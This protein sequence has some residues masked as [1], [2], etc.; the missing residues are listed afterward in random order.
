[1]QRKLFCNG[2]IVTPD[3][4]TKADLLVEGDKVLDV[5]HSIRSEDAQDIDCR[6]KLLLP[7]LVDAHVH[8]R[9]P[10][11]TSKEDF[12]SGT[13]AAVLGGITTALVMPT[14]EP[15]TATEDDFAEKAEL[16]SRRLRCDVGLQVAIRRSGQAL[17]PINQLCGPVSYEVFTADVPEPF[18]HDDL[19]KVQDALARVAQIGAVAGIS[20]GDQS[21]LS[22]WNALP[23][24]RRVGFEEFCQSRPPAGEAMGIARAIVAASSTG[25][26]IHIRQIN[27]R[28][29][30]E[31]VRR[32]KDLCD[33]TVETT[34]QCLLFDKRVYETQGSLAKGSPPFRAS[35]DVAALRAAVREGLVDIVATDHAPHTL[36]EKKLSYETF[37]D[38]PGGM[39]GVQ[40]FL[41]AML[42][43]VSEG[44][45]SLEDVVR[46]CSLKPA[47]RFGFRRRK[48]GLA[49]GYDADIVVVDPGRGM[50]IRNEDQISKAGYTIFNGLQ[51]PMALDQVYLRGALVVDQRGFLR[52]FHGELIKPA[53]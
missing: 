53:T 3:G 5:A 50:Q 10:G 24:S 40:T 16:A 44:V 4:L 2:T 32:L 52:G 18:L 7:G 20:P 28:A 19:A 37:A 42:H 35:E 8:F 9:D 26:R 39:P 23:L 25:C 46:A 41:P 11:L 31:V 15:Y 49:Q 38:V 21:L 29:G 33:V 27:S 14:D 45:L 43:L 22:N 47:E 48:G 51:V 13:T 17:E 30:V 6:G 36:A 34:V 12:V 1:M